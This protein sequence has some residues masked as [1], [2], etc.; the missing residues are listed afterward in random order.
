MTVRHSERAVRVAEWAYGA[1][2]GLAR[3]TPAVSGSVP[4]AP[5]EAAGHRRTPVVRGAGE[6][7]GV[8]VEVAD[9][10]VG[11]PDDPQGLTRAVAV[12]PGPRAVGLGPE[13]PRLHV[14]V[15]R[16]QREPTAGQQPQDVRARTPVPGAGQ[17]QQRRVRAGG[18]DP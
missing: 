18:R 14:L 1:P 15:D 16:R 13:P 17:L 11:T 12:Q 8:H 10:T 3:R 2:G 6:D 9:R 4:A 5:V 7:E